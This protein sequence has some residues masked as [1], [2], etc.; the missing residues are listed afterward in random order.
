MTPAGTCWRRAASGYERK[1]ARQVSTTDPDAVAMKTRG[2]RA[3]L[4]RV[5][6]VHR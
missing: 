5:G 2:E 3:A 6:V 4:G 1:S